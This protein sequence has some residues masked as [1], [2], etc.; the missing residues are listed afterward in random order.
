MTEQ[1]FLETTRTAYDTFAEEYA[2][3]ERNDY[4]PLPFER[5]MLGAF[6]E[7]AR[8]SAGGL[9]VADLGCGPG[10]VTSFLHG[11]GVDVFGI[12]LSPEMIA[13]AR[14]ENPGL[15]FDVGSMTALDLPPAS[16]SGIVASYSII[17]VPDE[18]LPSLFDGFARVLAPGGEVLVVFFTGDERMRRTEAFGYEVA[19]DYH[20]RPADRVA[21]AMRA[22]GLVERARLLRG[23]E[24][25]ELLPRAFLFASKP[26]EA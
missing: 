19:L 21:E 15:R 25:H 1:G 13:L 22:A 20:L 23:P 7:Y 16:V 10:K 24:P 12:D 3:D 4:G 17:H 26:R 2:R 6:A 8:A 9:P 11:L 18:A 14:K 5:A